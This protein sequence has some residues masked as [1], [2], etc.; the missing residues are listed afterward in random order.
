MAAWTGNVHGN[1][2]DSER[3]GCGHVCPGQELR[4]MME[5][6]VQDGHKW[7]RDRANPAIAPKQ[8]DVAQ[9]VQKSKGDLEVVL[10]PPILTWGM[11]PCRDSVLTVD[12]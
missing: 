4:T 8:G 10:G 9:D 6:A 2:I 12:D 1:G 11:N 7:C 3:F 5:E